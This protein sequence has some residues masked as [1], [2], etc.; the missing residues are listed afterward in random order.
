MNFEMEY[1]Y[2]MGAIAYSL[3]GVVAY[4]YILFSAVRA[5]RWLDA[6]LCLIFFVPANYFAGRYLLQ[7]IPVWVANPISWHGLFENRQPLLVMAF[8]SGLLVAIVT[9]VYRKNK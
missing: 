4:T 8:I 6:I 3:C 9:Y 7:S 1:Y 2:S 5:R